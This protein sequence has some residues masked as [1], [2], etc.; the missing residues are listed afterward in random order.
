[1]SEPIKKVADVNDALNPAHHA[2][3]CNSATT[4]ALPPSHRSGIVEAPSAGCIL[5]SQLLLNRHSANAL[6][7][8]CT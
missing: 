6:H 3:R 2:D 4:L 5:H 1:M 7:G 8:A